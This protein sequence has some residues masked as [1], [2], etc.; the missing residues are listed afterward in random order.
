[1][2]VYTE[3]WKI[4]ERSCGSLPRTETEEKVL[5]AIGH[6]AILHA[7]SNRRDAEFRIKAHLDRFELRYQ[8]GLLVAAHIDG[9]TKIYMPTPYPTEKIST[10]LNIVLDDTPYRAHLRYE[11]SPHGGRTN[12]H[13]NFTKSRVS[14]KKTPIYSPGFPVTISPTG[15]I[16]MQADGS[17]VFFPPKE[18]K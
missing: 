4:Y 15:A 6:K 18:S 12:E 16:T 17:E 2:T 7:G 11:M 5:A 3:M 13:I 9:T 8:G 14:M 10:T 1:M